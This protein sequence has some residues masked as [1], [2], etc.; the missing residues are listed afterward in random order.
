MAVCPVAAAPAQQRSG[1]ALPPPQATI[2][3]AAVG[4]PLLF[5][6]RLPPPLLTLT[7]LPLN[8]VC[9]RQLATLLLQMDEAPRAEPLPRSGVPPPAVP[10]FVAAAVGT[11]QLLLL[12]LV[13]RLSPPPSRRLL[14]PAIECV[15]VLPL[16]LILRALHLPLPPPTTRLLPSL[17]PPMLL[18]P[19]RLL[20]P[21]P[22]P[23]RQALLPL[24]LPQLPHLQLIDCRQLAAALALKVGTGDAE[25]LA[26]AA[27]PPPLPLPHRAA[28]RAAGLAALGFLLPPPLPLHFSQ[29]QALGGRQATLLPCP[30]RIAVVAQQLS[31]VE[32]PG[33]LP[34]RLG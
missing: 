15:R 10:C 25:T 13:R 14:L 8:Q 19:L 6:S 24:H 29:V 2:S 30:I 21:L 1:C 17:G 33:P 11:P 20:A 27:V 23:G 12:L 18:L 32:V 3:R 22:L 16:L 4:A 31:S 28:V 7:L 5:N 9:R 34:R 26:R